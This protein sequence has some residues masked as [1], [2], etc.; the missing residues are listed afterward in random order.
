[1]ERF[2][3]VTYLRFHNGLPAAGPREV[4]IIEEHANAQDLVLHWNGYSQPSPKHVWAY[5]VE[6]V[7][8]VQAERLHGAYK[9][10]VRREG[11][12]PEFIHYEGQR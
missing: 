12:Q 9:G 7:D 1:M 6:G 4:A 3:L 10:Y 2:K 11:H 5:A 8:I